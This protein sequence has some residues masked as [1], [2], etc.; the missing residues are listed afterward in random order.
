MKNLYEN[1]LQKFNEICQIPHCS[2]NEGQIGAW[3]VNWAKEKNFA[4]KQDEVGN[5]IINVPAKGKPENAPVVVLQ[6]H[7]DMVCVK[8]EDCV[9][10][11]AKDP[12]QTYEENGWLKAKGTTLG[13]D[14]GIAVAM[15][16]A[17]A[18]DQTIV[19]P[20]LELLF[21]V[22]EE[23]GLTGANHLQANSL[24][25]KIL[26]NLDSE[27]EGEFTIGCAGGKD[28]HIELDLHYETIKK[29][30][31]FNLKISKLAGGHS[32]I[33]I[34]QNKANALQLMARIVDFISESFTYQIVQV[35]AGIAHN[36]IPRD[37]QITIAVDHAF[38]QAQKD[39]L[40]AFMDDLKKEFKHTDPE[41]DFAY[42]YENK[43]NIKAITQADS[44]KIIEMLMALP[45][46]VTFMSA[47][48]PQLVETSNNLA[49]VT[50]DDDKLK[51][52]TSQRS[53][54]AS[55]REFI[56][57]KIENVAKLAGAKVESGNGYPAWQPNWSSP[58]LAKCKNLYLELYKK[59]AKVNVIHAG[60]ECGIIGAKH[61]GMDMISMGPNIRSPHCPQERMEL[62]SLTKILNFV[63]KLLSAL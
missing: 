1:T 27:E 55:R 7:M 50:I 25:G 29:A 52:L 26:L 21:T 11:F 48:N 31:L 12:I 46:G 44:K 33:E 51:I 9:H 41:I 53:S 42:T 2:G 4:C 58:L 32:G 13:A 28:T 60:L 45:H 16:L 34:D 49:I 24:Q 3:L 39:Q 37:A 5:V 57:K 20:P 6:G 14:N 47:E 38:E 36:A 63:T 59:E 62:E 8:D 10:D 61:E 40:A 19:H 54:S 22:D 23:R 18:E 56:T 43:E 35:N 30:N 15:A 17:I